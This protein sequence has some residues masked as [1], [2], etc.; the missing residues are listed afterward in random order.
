MNQL[1]CNRLPCVSEWCY[2]A[3]NDEFHPHCFGLIKFLMNFGGFIHPECEGTIS[4]R[5]PTGIS[6]FV[7]SLT[8]R[9]SKRVGLEISWDKHLV[10]THMGTPHMWCAILDFFQ[11]SF[12]LKGY[13]IGEIFQSHQPAR[14]RR[15]NHSFLLWLFFLYRFCL[16]ILHKRSRAGWPAF[17]ARG[18]YA[19]PTA[20]RP[21]DLLPEDLVIAA[22]VCRCSN[23]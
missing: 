2:F 4:Q 5:S 16:W 13:K 6:R 14:W 11:F 18:F 22:F 3:G 17:A 7:P 21:F 8:T 1:P 15:L 12:I 19:R 23:K 10:G 20:Q 9:L